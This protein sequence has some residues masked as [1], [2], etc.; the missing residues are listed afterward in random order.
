[1]NK[2][3]SPIEFDAR[4]SAALDL[5]TAEAEAENIHGG[6]L[7]HLLKAHIERIIW[8]NHD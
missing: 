8:G 4:L 7:W 6:Q 1:M 3:N 5:A 2:T